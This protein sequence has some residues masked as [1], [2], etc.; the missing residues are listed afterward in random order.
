[1]FPPR[2]AAAATA[3]KDH[4]A[5]GSWFEKFRTDDVLMVDVVAFKG[6][7]ESKVVPGEGVYLL[8]EKRQTVLRGDLAESLAP[9][10]DGSRTREQI[11]SAL[12]ARFSAPSVVGG[13]DRLIEAGLVAEVE[14][15]TDRRQHGFWE[16]AGLDAAAAMHA[17]RGRSVAVERVGSVANVPLE[18]ALE[19]AGLSRPDGPPDLTVVL[20]DDFLRPALADINS[21]ALTDKRPWLLVKPVGET[22]WI[23]PVFQ[24]GVTA[25]WECL[26][27][28]VRAVRPVVSYLAATGDLPILARADTPLTIDL[29]VRLAVLRATNWLAGSARESEDVVTL[30]MTAIQTRRH[31]LT[32]RPQCPACGDRELFTAQAGRPVLFTSRPRTGPAD[33]GYRT[34]DPGVFVAKYGHLV[35]PITGIVANLVNENPGSDV[36]H[37][38]TAGNNFAL[39]GMTSPCGRSGLRSRAGG[40]GMSEQQARASALGEAI[41]RYCGVFQG[42]EP[43]IRRAFADFDPADVLH[44]DTLQQFSAKQITDRDEWNGRGIAFHRVTDPFDDDEPIEWTPVW[45]VT[46]KR[47]K[48]IPTGFLYYG[49]PQ[50]AGRHVV[51]ANSNGSAA[52][53]TVEDATL[54]AFFELVER[55]AVALWWYNRV[56]RPEIDLERFDEPYFIK[57]R[58][59]YRESGRE[60]WLL[61]LTSDLAIPVVVALSRNPDSPSEDIMMGFGAH[62][63]ARI[64]IARAMTELNQMEPSLRDGSRPAFGDANV[65]EWLN[66]ATLV[67]QPYLAPLPGSASAIADVSRSAPVGDLLEDLRLAQDIVESHGMEMLVHD[68]TR[69]DIGLPVVKV[70]V[71]GLRHF[72]PR[73]APGRLYDVPVRLGWIPEPLTEAELNPIGMFL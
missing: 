64:A 43:R 37:T 1:M 56:Q 15:T 26:A 8:S 69:P 73:L 66:T 50:P 20:T 46:E 51:A 35:S 31:P 44:P 30:D 7:I 72:W 71:P 40:K 47:H 36:V 33:G 28:R 57:W 25:C 41:E 23:G 6:F 52:G 42:D 55:D 3:D 67:N 10:L 21:A 70:V 2:P 17:I 22:A 38:Y 9:L 54:Q 34:T 48:H 24:P 45:S 29:A 62:F 60:T 11:V 59:R 14:A 16:L 39:Q 53:T 61:D 32:R 27:S 13:I 19:H 49:Y 5:S 63:D 65:V 18:T 12:A 4:G 58:A 68:Q